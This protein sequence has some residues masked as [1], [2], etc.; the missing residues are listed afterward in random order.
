[1]SVEKSINESVEKSTTSQR[2]V[3]FNRP[4]QL[5]QLIG[6]NTTVIVTGRR[7]GKTDSIAAVR[8]IGS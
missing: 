5:T 2:K 6:A 3:Y 7:T 4:Q 1:M 8:V